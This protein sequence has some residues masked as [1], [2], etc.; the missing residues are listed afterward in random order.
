MRATS[1]Q[2]GQRIGRC[3]RTRRAALAL[4]AAS[5]PMWAAADEIGVTIIFDGD[6][7]RGVPIEEQEVTLSKVRHDYILWTAVQVDAGGSTTPY[8]G[9]SRVYF[10]PFVSGPPLKSGRQSQ[11]KSPKLH[12]DVPL[13]AFKYTVVG[14]HCPDAPLDPRI[15]VQ[16]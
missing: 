1:F 7:P 11:L 9:G 16:D 14:D 8:E 6:C 12:D 3:A 2:A 10:D 4:L 5:L 13:V 15:R